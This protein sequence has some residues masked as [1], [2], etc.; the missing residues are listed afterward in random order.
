MKK[1]KSIS[2]FFSYSN[3][4]RLHYGI[5]DF[6]CLQV[7]KKTLM[8]IQIRNGIFLQVGERINPI[9]KNHINHE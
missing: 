8:D 9:L 4:S 1:N 5:Y 3:F 6:V 7:N 2:T